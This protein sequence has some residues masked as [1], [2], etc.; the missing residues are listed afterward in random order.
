MMIAPP[1][2]NSAVL[3]SDR[4]TTCRVYHRYDE[5]IRLVE[6]WVA[7]ENPSVWGCDS[8][9]VRARLS[10]RIVELTLDPYARQLA[11]NLDSVMRRLPQNPE[12]FRGGGL[13]ISLRT[14]A[15]LISMRQCV[16]ELFLFGVIWAYTLLVI[17]A[18][19][20]RRSPKVS[21]SA[22]ILLEPGGN[23]SECDQKFTQYCRRGPIK[24]LSTASLIIVRSN[25]PPA[26]KTNVDFEYSKFPLLHLI[27][28]HLSLRHK[29]ALLIQHLRAPAALV[30]ASLLSPIN[31]L[32]AKDIAW[33]PLVHWLDRERLIESIVGT[34]SSFVSQPLWVKGFTRQHFRYHMVWYSQNFVPK[35]YKGETDLT[36]L[37]PARHMR[38][39]VHWVWTEGFRVYLKS[40]GQVC[41]INVIGPMVWY[42]P[43]AIP[44]TDCTAINVA[45]FDVTP[46]PRGMQVSGAFKNYYSVQTMMKFVK[47]IVDLCKE[48]E[49][50]Y[51]RRFRIL[52]KHKRRPSTGLHDSRYLDYLSQLE[53]TNPDFLIIDEH[54]N[55]FGL[56]EHCNLSISVPYTSTCYVASDLNRHAIYYDPF[57]ELEPHFESNPYV[58]FAA[59]KSELRYMFQEYLNFANPV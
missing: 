8:S 48:M 6:R 51:K 42:F 52:L 44:D 11:E 54:T 7:D 31:L 38:A 47:D 57:S 10:Q 13:T 30:R 56:L 25:S 58:H 59:G 29:L 32:L 49:G 2:P 53:L 18:A 22:T 27:A 35:I 39:D 46:F 19:F 20:F 45:V 36:P 37:P 26:V 14:G 3:N 12:Q 16:P 21:Q 55:L 1:E 34:T 50:K 23:W 4:L 24:P 17:L 41:E 5:V 15:V 28:N 9:Q 43:E 33:I 40:L